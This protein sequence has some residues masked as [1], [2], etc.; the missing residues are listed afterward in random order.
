M[1]FVISEDIIKKTS[2]CRSNF[3]CLSGKNDCICEIEDSAEDKVHFV[4]SGDTPPI[5]DYRMGF[6]YSFLCN[7]P[8]RKALYNQYRV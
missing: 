1:K 6:G 7:C 4:K 2:R 5:C 3:S 8:V